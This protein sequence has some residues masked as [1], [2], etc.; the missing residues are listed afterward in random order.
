MFECPKCGGDDLAVQAV[1][2]KEVYINR[3]GDVIDDEGGDIEFEGPYRCC[4]CGYYS[5]ESFWIQ[6]D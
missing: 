1:E 2:R 6:E 3:E 5:K 4:D